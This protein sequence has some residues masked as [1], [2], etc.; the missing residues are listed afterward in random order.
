MVIGASVIEDV[1]RAFLQGIPPG[2]VY[3]LVALGFVLTYK[4]SGVFNLAFGAQAYVSAALYFKLTVSEEWAA[5]PAV[6]VSVFV[7]SP[8]L[9]FLLER[10]IF[11]NL[12]SPSPLPGLVLTI[13]LSVAIPSLFDE[14]ANFEVVPGRTP[15]GILP[16]GN[17]VLYDPFG[18]YAFNRNELIAM[19][20]ALV[21]TVALGVL[22]KFSALGLQMRAVVESRRM[23]ELHGVSADR[24][25]TAAWVLS[26][27]F[28]GMAG[29]L[30]APRFQT[31]TAA[32]FFQLMIIAIAAAA[33][34][35]LSSLPRALVGGL[36]LG[37][38]IAEIT[39]FLPR[40]SSTYTWLQPLQDSVAPAVPFVVLFLAILLVSAVRRPRVS[41]PLAGVDPPT[42]SPAVSARPDGRRAVARLLVTGMLLVGI[43]AIVFFRADQAWLFV[44]TQAVIMS[45]I[46][47]SF[48]V[49]TGMGGEISLCQGA[50]AA[51][52]AYACFQLAS[53]NQI[54]PMIAALIGGVIAAGVGAALSFPIRRLG[55]V[56]TAIGT[57][58]FA[59]F[60]DSV[61]IEL[62]WVSGGSALF[63][64]NTV[65]R[66]TIG[67]FDFGNDKSFLALA[68]VVL[69]VVALAVR[70]LQHGT[71]GHTL[72]AVSGSEA[73]AQ[74]IGI[75]RARGR[76]VAFAISG[77]IAALGGAMLSMLQE[78][79]K[80]PTNFTPFI[81]LF[82]LVVV[83]V[84]GVRS[85]AGAIHAG[86]SFALFDVVVLKGALV[87]WVLRSP[88]R[89]P[90]LFPIS[91][92][93]IFILFG[94]AAIQFAKHPEGLLEHAAA[95]RAERWARR[96]EDRRPTPETSA[97]E[98]EPVGAATTVG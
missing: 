60:F 53:E 22:F 78:D 91:S 34:G 72:S 18:V 94:L 36:G 85:V 2:A 25:S 6:L 4:T 3:A 30:I 1:F 40:W 56:W 10:L 31:L 42:R 88:D 13:G 84:L 79:V 47:L 45:I 66:P 81:A 61:V 74:S 14:L 70:N 12:R 87:G 63:G 5:L 32:N 97:Q 95:R 20:V 44:V 98:G 51:I 89:I 28:A 62:P 35:G 38:F 86:A 11:R 15:E 26:S 7:V 33:I 92:S 48:T 37:V 23:T 80:Y 17:T 77:F 46:F 76:L 71:L 43:A 93:W 52:G 83:A 82:W 58:A 9:G 64:G 29:V 68:I 16:G 57:L 59:Y 19:G 27:L 55:G 90:D 50:F 69:V 39:T 96:R 65:P 24:A 8:L 67:P 21:A 73:G 49:V 54:P 41:D 75:S